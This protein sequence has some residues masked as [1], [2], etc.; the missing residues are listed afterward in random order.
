[1]KNLNDLLKYRSLY[2]RI[3][4]IVLL[5]WGGRDALSAVQQLITVISP[6]Q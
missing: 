3:A 1:M 6:V 4:V 2:G 5:I